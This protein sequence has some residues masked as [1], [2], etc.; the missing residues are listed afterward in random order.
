MRI[1]VTGGNGQLGRELF[2]QQNRLPQSEW[3]FTD[4]DTLDI[5]DRQTVEGY[6]NENKPN[7]VINCAAYTAVDQAEKNQDAAF[8][9]NAI[10]PG[11]LADLCLKNEINFVH[12]S[13]DYV[14]N[15]RSYVPYNETVTPDPQSVYGL[16]KSEGEKSVVSVN[17]NAMIIRTSWLYSA[18]GNNFVKTMLRLGRERNELNV[19]F[20][21]IGSPTYAYDL[22]DCIISILNRCVDDSKNWE[23]GIYHYSNEGVCSWYDFA[24]AVHHMSNICCSIKPIESKDFPTLAKRPFYSVLNKSKI[25]T[26][27]GIT[28]PYWRDSLK[29]CINKIQNHQS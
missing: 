6:F 28:I 1:L 26:T 12:I 10:A 24:L 11:Y 3:S 15:G 18:Y 20:D 29:A 8:G 25:K 16:S 19:V 13:T 9:L 22:A 21:Q 17:P 4:V 27:Y 14:F 2:D 5:T 23:P 7:V